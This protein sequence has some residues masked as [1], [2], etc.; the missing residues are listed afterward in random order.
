LNRREAHRTRELAESVVA[1]ATEHGFP[2]WISYG[3][4]LS[5]WALAAGGSTAEGIERIK[6]GLAAYRTTGAELSL[7]HFLSLLAEAYGRAGQAETG[8][9][10]LHQALAVVDRTEEPVYQA[11]LYRV[12]GGSWR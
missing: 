3:T 7:S 4:I 12:K 9:E 5:G 11:D 2:H 6:E 10:T 8:L 1:L